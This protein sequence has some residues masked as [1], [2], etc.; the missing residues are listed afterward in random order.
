MV[1]SLLA[2]TSR[3]MSSAYLTNL[4]CTCSG[5]K[6]DALMTKAAGPIAE[7]CTMLAEI[8]VL[9]DISL[10]NLVT[11]Q[12]MEKADNPVVDVIWQV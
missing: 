10:L 6:S 11:C 1:L 7:P 5:C 4:F 3:Y 12:I 2:P 9:A 8:L